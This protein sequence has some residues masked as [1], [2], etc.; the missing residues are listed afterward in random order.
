MLIQQHNMKEEHILYRLA[1]QT[2]GHNAPALAARLA[3]S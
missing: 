1:D 2:L 3:Q